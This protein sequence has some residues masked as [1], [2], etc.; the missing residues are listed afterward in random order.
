M[1]ETQQLQRLYIRYALVHMYHF[2]NVLYVHD[3]WK[4]GGYRSVRNHRCMCIKLLLLPRIGEVIRCC[5]IEAAVMKQHRIG[6]PQICSVMEEEGDRQRGRLRQSVRSKALMSAS[7]Y[8]SG[9]QRPG[10]HGRDMAVSGLCAPGLMDEVEQLV[11]H[12]GSGFP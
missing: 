1:V 8:S 9:L 7:K 5:N 11:N 6:W 2:A 4:P 10:P 12:E 3:V